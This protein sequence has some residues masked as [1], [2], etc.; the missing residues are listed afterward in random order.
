GNGN[1]SANILGAATINGDGDSDV[2]NLLDASSAG[3]DTYT[4]TSSTFSKTGS[5]T[6][7]YAASNEALNLTANGAA[8][9]IN[10]NSTAVNIPVFIDAAG[11]SDTITVSNTASGAPVTI[12]PTADFDNVTV[13]NGSAI[14]PSSDQLSALTV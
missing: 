5:A 14:I 2:I 6:V 4:I 8:N 3:A 13:T 9:S 12:S 10:V 1:I 7:T 11:G